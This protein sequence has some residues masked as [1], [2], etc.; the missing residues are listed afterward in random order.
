MIFKA[1]TT[2]KLS[3]WNPTED[4]LKGQAFTPT[5]ASNPV[6]S[7][8]EKVTDGQMSLWLAGGGHTLLKFSREV[9]AVPASVLK[10]ATDEVC[11]AIEKETGN[12]PGRK[13]RKEIEEAKRFELLASAFGVRKAAHV[14]I[15]HKVGLLHIDTTTG[16]MVDAIGTT[17]AKMLPSGCQMGL[18]NTIVSPEAAMSSWVG[19]NEPPPSFTI[20]RE[21][22][23]EGGEGQSITIKNM[24]LDD[25]T[26]AA[27]AHIKAGKTVTKLAMTHTLPGDSLVHF[28]LNES[29]AITR[30]AIGDIQDD[31]GGDKYDL[32]VMEADFFLMAELFSAVRAAVTEALGGVAKQDETTQ[33]GDHQ[34]ATHATSA[35]TGPVAKVLTELHEMGA[36]VTVRQGGAMLAAFPDAA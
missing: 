26:I 13:M 3:G 33:G 27:A 28:V 22:H 18:L 6:T 9:R 11:T 15:D 4:E 12:K 20:D 34:A 8:W 14:W 29:G 32:S 19:L 21:C 25:A 35:S 7:G 5:T 36:T 31:I 10:R 30:L 1:L 17:V 24:A 2:F 23:L 16:A